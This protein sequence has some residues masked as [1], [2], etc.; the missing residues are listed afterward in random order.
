LE[1]THFRRRVEIKRIEEGG[2]RMKSFKLI[3]SVD[4]EGKSQLKVDGPGKEE[5]L[6]SQVI[7]YLAAELEKYELNMTI[8]GVGKRVL[9][10]MKKQTPGIQLIK[11]LPPSMKNKQ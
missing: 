10:E 1:D 6:K 11:D 7:T 4:E 3:V 8:D 5:V 9:E 2:F